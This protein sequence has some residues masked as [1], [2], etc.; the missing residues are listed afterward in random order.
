MGKREYSAI[1]LAQKL[2]LFAE[3][4]D[5]IEGLVADF[6]ARGWL[7]DERF[8]EQ[9]AHARKSKYGSAKI[10]HELRQKGVDESLIDEAIASIKPDELENAKAVWQKKFKQAPSNQQE[11]AKQARFLQGRGFGFD[12]I[13]Q[14]L[15]FKEDDS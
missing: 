1:E 3:E 15:N 2:K 5:D 10:A 9:R 12:V 4:S 14:V 13:K 6:K 11:W 7:S 8:A